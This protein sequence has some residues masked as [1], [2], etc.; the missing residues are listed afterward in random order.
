[1]TRA[2]LKL[3]GNDLSLT[4]FLVDGRQETKRERHIDW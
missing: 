3:L 1:M 4:Y 2:A